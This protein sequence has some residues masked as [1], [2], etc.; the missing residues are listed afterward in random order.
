MD[1]PTTEDRGINSG[2]PDGHRDFHNFIHDPK[3]T[4]ANY[5][6]GSIAPQD[7][8]VQ[9]LLNGN[10]QYPHLPQDQY[11][12]TSGQGFQNP[13]QSQFAYA[14]PAPQR[15]PSAFN[16][17]QPSQLLGPQT[18]QQFNGEGNNPSLPFRP[19]SSNS[20]H[21]DQN[22][23]PYTGSAPLSQ[24]NYSEISQQLPYQRTSLVPPSS[25][26]ASY[27][28]TPGERPQSRIG[29]AP[30][31]AN[32]QNST[33]SASRTYHR[34]VT[35]FETLRYIYYAARISKLFQPVLS[36]PQI[37]TSLKNAL[38]PRKPSLS[39]NRH[40]ALTILCC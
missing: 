40:S 30:P 25:I 28:P 4:V 33:V 10:H 9:P 7:P 27:P 6:A 12:G 5:L 18:S 15:P 11:P 19:I 24:N 29:P 13:Q 26:L 2:S 39:A 34:L 14:Q 3:K 8:G 35:E 38:F 23:T 21:F 20:N 31:P 17:N 1:E 37:P 36:P 22:P 16:S 32:T